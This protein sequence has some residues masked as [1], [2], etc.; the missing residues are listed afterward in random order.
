MRKILLIL[1]IGLAVVGCGDKDD[2]GDDPVL[3]KCN[4][5]EHYLPCTC[6]GTDCTCAII[7]R[8]YITE[9]QTN[10]QIPIYQ[11]V[12]VSDAQAISATGN[13]TAGWGDLTDSEKNPLKGKIKEVRIIAKAE[14]QTWFYDYEIVGNQLI[15][16]IQYD[17]SWAAAV[18][19][20]ALSKSGLT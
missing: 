1:L 17:C 2:G 3:C 12:G 7:P 20:D 18:F 14:D 10:N 19:N 4:P 13:I 6:G 8:G 16:K 9:Y 15:I 5:K 11:T